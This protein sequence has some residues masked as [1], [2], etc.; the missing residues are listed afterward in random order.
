MKLQIFDD[1]KRAA[2]FPLTHLRSVGDLRCGIM[3]LRQRLESVFRE[4]AGY[5][6][7]PELVEL[8][9]FRHPDWVINQPV[10][11]DCLYINSRIKLTAESYRQIKALDL[12]TAIVNAGT[13]LAIRTATGISQPPDLDILTELKI[14]ILKTELE[15]YRH[16]AD[17][18]QD[19]FR[20]LKYDFEHYFQDKDN[21]FETEPGVT[22][23]DP[24]SIWI[25]DKVK[26][27]PGVVLD[28][29]G[30]PI[31]IDDEA[32]I[33]ANAVIIGPCYIGKNSIVKIGAKIYEGCS[34][35]PVCK[36]G[37]E[38]E[39]TIIQAYTNKQHD[40]FLGHAFLGEWVNLGADTNNS[41]L[42]N[43]YKNVGYYSY[44]DQDFIDSGSMFL[45]CIIGDHVKLGINSTINTGTVIGTG[46]NLWGKDL[47]SGFIPDLSW[48]EAS[49]L[50]EYRF[51]AFLQTASIVKARRKLELCPPEIACLRKI[52]ETRTR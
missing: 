28:A 4:D 30:G 44:L 52:S 12:E 38:L 22:V 24:Y 29:S 21:F 47:I 14:S 31:V 48:G 41:D 46:S 2:F 36:I 40:G 33:M 45:G 16:P 9:Q 23:L 5:I 43:T 8:Y 15:F 13:V 35:G 19:N 34:I 49:K 11:T 17:L 32:T 27:K 51:D 3:K 20:L 26:L 37:G 39:G 50:S 7:D 6:I 42:K 25:G 1:S 10:K 18:I